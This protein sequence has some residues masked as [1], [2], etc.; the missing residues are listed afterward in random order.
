MAF[1]ATDKRRCAE[2]ETQF[3]KIVYAGKVDNNTMTKLD[4]ERE[5]NLMQ[6]IADDYRVIERAEMA[7]R[8]PQLDLKK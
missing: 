2:R 3:R 1:S 7:H 8:A 6:E 4:A 5:I